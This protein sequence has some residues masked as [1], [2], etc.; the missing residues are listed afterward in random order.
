MRTGIEIDVTL[1]TQPGLP[2]KRGRAA[3]PSR[4]TTRAGAA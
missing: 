4:N 1:R 2:L 3:T